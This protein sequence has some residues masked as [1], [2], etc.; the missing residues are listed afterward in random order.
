MF[1]TYRSLKV[2]FIFPLSSDLTTRF[3]LK[4]LHLQTLG[5]HA[6]SATG[7]FYVTLNLEG[8]LE[9]RG[10][11]VSSVLFYS[12]LWL[13]GRWRLIARSMFLIS[14]CVIERKGIRNG[15]FGGCFKILNP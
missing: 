7:R 3:S 14:L 9:T 2:D 10:E 13:L 8:N 15:C 11:P 12:S 1:Y 6:G 4:H 5:N